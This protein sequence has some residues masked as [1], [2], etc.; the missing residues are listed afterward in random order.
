MEQAA[1]QAVCDVLGGSVSPTEAEAVL[2]ATVPLRVPAG[3]TLVREGAEGSGLYFLLSGQ[4]EIVKERRDGAGQRLAV[5]DAPSLL[6]ELSLVTDGP[7]TATARA[8]TDC[9]LRVLGRSHFRLRLA[10]DDL[11]A[12]KL[13]GAMAEVLARRLIRINE[14]VLQLSSPAVAGSRVEELDRLRDKLFK[15]WAF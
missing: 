4:V 3:S 6:G 9:D 8:L 2:A 12:Y 15:E 11:L 14:T 13:L 1:I 7:H 10:A 5:V